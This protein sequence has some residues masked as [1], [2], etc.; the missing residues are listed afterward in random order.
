MHIAFAH[1]YT[2]RVLRGHETVGHDTRSVPP[3]P[4]RAAYTNDRGH[5]KRRP[6]RH[7]TVSTGRQ[8]QRRGYTVSQ[9]RAASPQVSRGLEP[10][11]TWPA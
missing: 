3:P 11:R 4:P 8:S 9:P 1:T 7:V 5:K 10:G 2:R 6:R